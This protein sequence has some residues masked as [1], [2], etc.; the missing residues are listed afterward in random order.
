MTIN[1]A[2]LKILNTFYLDNLIVAYLLNITL[3]GTILS[4]LNRIHILVPFFLK[5]HLNIINTCTSTF[6]KWSFNFSFSDI[7]LCLYTYSG[8]LSSLA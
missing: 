1:T 2:L 7:P 8:P 5:N 4:Q 3:L 6:Y